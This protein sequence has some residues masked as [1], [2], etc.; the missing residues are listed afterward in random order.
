MYQGR[1]I[2][3]IILTFKRIKKKKILE[4]KKLEKYIENIFF[5]SIY[6]LSSSNSSSLNNDFKIFL[7]YLLKL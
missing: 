3:L 6:S 5:T 2:Y 7:L 1:K 4:S